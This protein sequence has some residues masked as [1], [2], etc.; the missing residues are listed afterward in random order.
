M[1]VVFGGKAWV[2]GRPCHWEEGWGGAPP[3]EKIE[4]SG[5]EKCI[6]VDPR[7]GFVMDNGESTLI[8]P[9]LFLHYLNCS[10][11]RIISDH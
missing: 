3:E 8:I 11:I 5:S 4:I 10:V 1:A 9:F 7:D 6:L 2:G